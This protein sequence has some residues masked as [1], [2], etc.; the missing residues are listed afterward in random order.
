MSKRRDAETGKY[1]TEEQASDME[2]NTWTQEVDFDKNKFLNKL[3]QEILNEYDATR[4]GISMSQIEA[5]FRKF[6]WK[7]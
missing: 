5:V 6:G 1:I 4:G 7:I 3:Y 2:P